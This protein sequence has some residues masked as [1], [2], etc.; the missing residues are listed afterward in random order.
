MR[1][2]G[3]CRGGMTVPVLAGGQCHGGRTV[4]VLAGGQGHGG[5]AV[6]AYGAGALVNA[7]GPQ[8]LQ[9]Q[10]SEERIR[11]TRILL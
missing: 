7:Q 4:P 6:T 5:R 9:L 10:V 1:T 11:I 8:V 2:G 3:Q